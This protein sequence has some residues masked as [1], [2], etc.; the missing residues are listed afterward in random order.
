MTARSQTPSP[1]S[2]VGILQMFDIV[3]QGV[4]MMRFA[5]SDGARYVVSFSDNMGDGVVLGKR[6]LV[7]AT[8]YGDSDYL[9]ATEPPLENPIEGQAVDVEDVRRENEE[10][11]R[12][13][14]RID[15]MMKD[16]SNACDEAQLYAF[17]ELEKL[18]KKPGC[19][20]DAT[21]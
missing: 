8:A 2:F 12:I 11:R 13:I 6:Y 7:N 17:T 10:L 1:I 18:D 16:A 19:I 14:K 4:A 3:K 15:Y 9:T 5:A 20:E 21:L